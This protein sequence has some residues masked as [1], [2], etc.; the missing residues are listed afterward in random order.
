[1]RHHV[2]Y[3]ISSTRLYNIMQTD[4]HYDGMFGR[5]RKLSKP[6]RGGIYIFT[7]MEWISSVGYDLFPLSASGYAG[8]LQDK[9]HVVVTVLVVVLSLLS[10]ILC[11]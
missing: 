8:T 6:L 11:N 4:Q 9:M 7:I 2:C 10:L 1:M 5:A 3:G